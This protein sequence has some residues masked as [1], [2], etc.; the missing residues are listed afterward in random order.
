[1][2]HT[3]ISKFVAVALIAASAT[4]YGSASTVRADGGGTPIVTEDGRYN[5]KVGDRVVV[6]PSIE[7]V[8]V[9]G[10]DTNSNGLFLARFSKDD[11]IAG[12]ATRTSINGTVTLTL[13]KPLTLITGYRDEGSTELVTEIKTG[14]VYTVSWTGGNYG[15]NGVAQFAKTF[16]G[17]WR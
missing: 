9:W 8:D 14:A 2:S 17:G 16:E 4:V 12:N 7:Y 5:P 1:M 6:Y 10:V 15:A 11:L 3:Q 13:D